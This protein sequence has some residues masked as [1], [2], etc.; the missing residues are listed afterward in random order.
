MEADTSLFFQAD[1]IKG[2]YLLAKK[3]RPK[4]ALRSTKLSG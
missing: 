4:S 3:A 2:A 1:E